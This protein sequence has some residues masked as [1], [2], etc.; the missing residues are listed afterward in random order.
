MRLVQDD[1]GSR[2]VAPAPARRAA[3]VA[4]EN[5]TASLLTATDARWIL[6]RRAS[7]ALEGGSAAVLPSER[8]RMLLGLASRLGLRPFDASLIIAIV[9]DGRRSGR[10]ALGP[11]VESR[12]SVLPVAAAALPRAAIRTRGIVVALIAFGVFAW[13]VR[14]LV[15]S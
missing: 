14:W 7:E 10:G 15:S 8:R 5:R 9:Q 11:E 13:L 1:P 12:L 3:A 6:A 4:N 2:P